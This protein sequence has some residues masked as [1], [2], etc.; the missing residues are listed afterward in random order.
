[1]VHVL[2]NSGNCTKAVDVLQEELEVD[3]SPLT[4][5]GVLRAHEQVM[6]D[7]GAYLS[8]PDPKRRPQE[9]GMTVRDLAP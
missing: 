4:C 8:T 6:K 3:G 7:T 5:D 1:M 9:G 2:G